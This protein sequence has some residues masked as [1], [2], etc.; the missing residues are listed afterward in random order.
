MSHLGDRVAALVDGQLT[1][2]AVDRATTHLASCRPCRDLFELER[3][4]KARLTSLVGPEPAPELVGR[5]LAMRGPAGPLPPRP[6]YVPG[7]PRPQ[8]VP[9]RPPVTTGVRSGAQR[10]QAT[11]TR[12]AGRP[13]VLTARR[14]RLAAAVLGAL[15]VV[16][17][18]VAGVAVGT[19][20]GGAT[21]RPGS[22][23]DTF[24]TSPG[25]SLVSGNLG[26]G[27][28]LE[29]FQPPVTNGFG[30]GLVAGR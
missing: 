4:T 16:G 1:A 21:Q 19:S 17:V 6:G 27:T 20:A 22:P 23:M 28:R 14:T 3:L 11:S 18:G 5:L 8:P 26:S 15:S 10:W 24:V 9:L 13:P 2:D 30:R 7:T 12:P 29:L 25:T